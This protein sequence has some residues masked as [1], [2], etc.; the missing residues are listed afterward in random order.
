MFA[1]RS[2]NFS[3][4]A[5]LAT[6]LSVAMLPTASRAYT[7]E[8]QQACSDDAVR[9]CNAEIPD[10]DRIT[11]C[12]TRNKSRLSAGCRVFFRSGPERAVTPTAAGRAPARKHVGDN[13]PKP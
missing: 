12:M 5:M 11:V 3:L 1:V 8:Q 6:A 13:P 10:V 2:R 7:P 9:L 4:G